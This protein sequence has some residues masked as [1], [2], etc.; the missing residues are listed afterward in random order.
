MSL[1]P[2][3]SAAESTWED[4]APHCARRWLAIILLMALVLRLG[5]A[6][7]IG[8]SPPQIFDE[9]S[10]NEIAGS[11]ATSGRFADQTGRLTSLRPP[12]HPALLA[13][14]YW[15]WGEHHYLAARLVQALVGALTVLPLYSLAQGM[16]S[17]RVAL[18]AVALF[19]VE[20]SLMG[21]TGLLLSETLF[22]FLLVLSCLLMQ[23][24]L[25]DGRFHW[26]FLFGVATGL[27]ALTR[28][29]ML[30]MVPVFC[31][32]LYWALHSWRW[33]RRLAL[34]ATVVVG[35][36]V[37]VGPW[38]V[39]NTRLEGTLTTIDAIG[40]RNLMMGNYEYTPL[41]RSWDTISILAGTEKSWEVLLIQQHP[42]FGRLS[43][44]ARDKL[45]MR[46]GLKFILAHPGLTLKRSCVKFFDFWQ[47]ERTLLGGMKMGWWGNFSRPALIAAAVLM[48]A[49][50][51]GV[52]LAGIL[53]LFLSRPND[54]RMHVFIILLIL[55][56]AAVHTLIFA[57]SRY[58]L[59]L[60]PLLLIYS[61]SLP[62]FW[63][64]RSLRWHNGRFL[65]AVVL[66]FALVA[67]WS[68]QF[69]VFDVGRLGQ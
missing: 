67:S 61:A 55:L 7:W 20:P 3:T 6:W 31:L 57:H 12:L 49:A 42:E 27:A 11:L 40:G 15:V 21:Y 36:L 5:I 24:L 19:A 8:A 54:L 28:S 56:T 16:F 39:R 23:R 2:T 1:N 45:A 33:P 69:I 32:F 34:S 13:A 9:Q 60:M 30:P 53:G 35:C 25:Q 14:V 44:G 66:G 46:H 63:K 26:A 37:V 68:V 58:R 4:I 10:Y 62:F 18:L 52:I 64:T 47:L 50:N 59:P 41:T 22:T 43:Q 65:T 48:S 51:A 17:R 38:I 29:L